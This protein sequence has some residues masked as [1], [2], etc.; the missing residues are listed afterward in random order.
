MLGVRGYPFSS[1]CLGAKVA[2][3][4]SQPFPIILLIV[5]PG[6]SS[7]VMFQECTVF[8]FSPLPFFS[9]ENKRSLF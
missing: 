6:F 2:E 3:T 8:L 1:S 9:I 7:V 4:L 5:L